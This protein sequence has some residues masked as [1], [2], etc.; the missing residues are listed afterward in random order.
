[1]SLAHGTLASGAGKAFSTSP[2]QHVLGELRMWC[3]TSLREMLPPTWENLPAQMPALYM[4]VRSEPT[5]RTLPPGLQEGRQQVQWR[6]GAARGQVWRPQGASL[7]CRKCSSRG[8]ALRDSLP[9]HYKLLHFNPLL[10]TMQTL[11]QK[12]KNTSAIRIF[13][14]IQFP[15]FLIIAAVPKPGLAGT[16]LHRLVS[17]LP[18]PSQ[19]VR[20]GGD[21]WSP[22]F[23]KFPHLIPHPPHESGHLGLLV[24]G[25]WCPRPSSL[26]DYDLQSPSLFLQPQTCTSHYIPG[27]ETEMPK[28]ASWLEKK[29]SIHTKYQ[30]NQTHTL[31]SP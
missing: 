1:M 28:P 6:G 22:A 26:E 14:S 23:L 4:E 10:E 25:L 3:P 20:G 16:P 30:N 2:L 8:D 18:L 29:S 19:A 27:N 12:K 24:T 13:V 9:F 11:I 17:P 7:H 15:G 31:T 5:S 21:G